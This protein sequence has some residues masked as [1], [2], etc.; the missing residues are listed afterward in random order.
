[1]Q[2]WGQSPHYRTYL[3][4][5][6]SFCQKKLLNCQGNK[7]KFYWFH[8]IGLNMI[9]IKSQ[10][11]VLVEIWIKELVDV[12][13]LA[14]R[15]LFNKI[16]LLFRVKYFHWQNSFQSTFFIFDTVLAYR[17]LLLGYKWFEGSSF[18]DIKN[19]LN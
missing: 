14:F 19:N 17:I 7:T 11:K 8:A 4:M 15:L 16:I 9:M 2:Y 18:S 10:S 12:Y 3:P 13:L 1:M 6:K 5:K